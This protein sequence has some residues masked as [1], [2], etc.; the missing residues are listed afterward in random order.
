MA[1]MGGQVITVSTAGLNPRRVA[2]SELICGWSLDPGEVFLSCAATRDESFAAGISDWRGKYVRYES[3]VGS[4]GGIV[5][6]ASRVLGSHTVEITA[7]GFAALAIGRRTTA[8]IVDAMVPGDLAIHAIVNC[9]TDEP[10][11]WSSWTA[12]LDG[13]ALGWEFRNED[14]FDALNTI[15]Q[16]G[17]MEWRV[18]ED[19]AFAMRARFGDVTHSVM[20]VEG[21]H[22]GLGRWDETLSN[23]VNDLQGIGDDGS[24]G[25]AARATASDTES[26]LELGRRFQSTQRYPGLTQPTSI[27]PRVKA[28]LERLKR[29]V[30]P[31][32]LNVNDLGGFWSEF[33]EG[34]R[35]LVYLASANA[36]LDVRV[37]SRIYTPADRSLEVL[38]DVWGAR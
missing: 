17:G 38:G 21:K 4:W 7:K 31:L 6:D 1:T 18:D 32:L 10:I 19:R 16:T 14:L 34:D 28:D 24:F 30:S 3:P 33:V 20:L 26:I 27:E 2:V 29:G 37:R 12:D 13:D 36:V 15:A 9:D 5:W 35:I 8:G 11:G 22:V 23:V 25:N